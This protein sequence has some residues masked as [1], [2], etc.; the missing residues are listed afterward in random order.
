MVVQY[1]KK[2]FMSLMPDKLQLQL[3]RESGTVLDGVKFLL[4]AAIV[5]DLI[6]LLSTGI[7][8]VMAKSFALSP[9]MAVLVNA[10]FSPATIVI[11]LI[12]VPIIMV[13]LA[14]LVNGLTYLLARV[15][16]GTG[17]FGIQFYQFAVVAGG[18]HMLSAAFGIIPCLGAVLTFALWIYFLY[19]AFLIYKSVHRL[20]NLR[21]AMVVIIPLLVAVLLA[22]MLLMY[23]TP[24]VTTTTPLPN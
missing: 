4:L 14:F 5:V 8:Y 19:L 11:S 2:M 16:G 10:Q 15:L 18:F 9:E 22:A 6:S 23:L 24:L 21:A 12:L 1:Y 20:D 13:L 3:Q 17:S 7:N